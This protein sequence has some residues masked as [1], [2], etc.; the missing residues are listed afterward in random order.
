LRQIAVYL[1]GRGLGVCMLAACLS[2]APL[3][4]AQSTTADITGTVTD[5]SGA[6]LPNAK[7]TLTNLG[8][9]EVRTGNTTAAGD[10]TFT[11]LSPAPTQSRSK[12][13]GSRRSSFPP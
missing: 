9:G 8:T 2:A 11:L 4:I 13:T 12:V 10:Y 3:A 6:I 5:N 1:L 7:V